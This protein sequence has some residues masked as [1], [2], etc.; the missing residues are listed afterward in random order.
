MPNGAI[1][2]SSTRPATEQP[3]EIRIVSHVRIT[4]LVGCIPRY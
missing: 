1:S 4:P 3:Q 2:S